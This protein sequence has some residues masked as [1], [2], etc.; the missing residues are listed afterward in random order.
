MFHLDGAEPVILLISCNEYRA[1]LF[2]IDDRLKLSFLSRQSECQETPDLGILD[3]SGLA[4]L[5]AAW[6][7]LRTAVA[8]QL[9]SSYV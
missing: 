8:P 7:T 6:H 2:S 9:S 4:P 3:K 5:A 1:L